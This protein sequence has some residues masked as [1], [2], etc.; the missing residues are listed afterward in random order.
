MD[1]EFDPQK[2]SKV[3]HRVVTLTTPGSL[4]I[5]YTL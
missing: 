3:E 5:L 2:F 1:T 4:L